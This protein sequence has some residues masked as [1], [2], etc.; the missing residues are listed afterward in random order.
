MTD[1][2]YIAS[3]IVYAMP[4]RAQPLRGLIN[5]MEGTEVHAAE[6]GK[7]VVSMEAPSA[8]D[9]AMRIDAIRDLPGVLS[10]LPVYHHVESLA[11]L[12]E[13]VQDGNDAA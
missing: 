1:E 9:L 7:L 5:T 6:S 3:M 2:A 4:D 8:G 13:E 12:E 10:V 11:S